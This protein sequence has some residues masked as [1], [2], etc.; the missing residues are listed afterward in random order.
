MFLRNGWKRSNVS[1]PVY[2]TWTHEWS[3][4]VSVIYE[5][6]MATTM[7]E[8]GGT[9]YQLGKAFFSWLRLPGTLNGFTSHPSCIFGIL[10]LI[11][12]VEKP[13]IMPKSP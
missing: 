9:M 6:L 5:N 13:E 2:T 10:L 12:F 8:C 3:T 4:V 11:K 7:F 1:F